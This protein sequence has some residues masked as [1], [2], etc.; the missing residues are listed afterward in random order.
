MIVV[1]GGTGVLGSAIVRRLL[2]AGHTARVLTR[3]PA[4]ASALAARG[5]GIAIADL[6]DPDALRVA[7]RDA[8]HVITTANAFTGGGTEAVSAVDLQGT[9]NLVA[10]AH[11]AGVR[12]FVFTSAR[13]PREFGAVD[14]FAAKFANE[15]YVRGSGIPYTILQ[16]TAFMETWARMILD[17][18]VGKGVARVFGPGDLPVNYVAVADVAAVAV[19]AL[20]RADTVN[21]A[22]EIGGPENL[23]TL[24]VVEIVERVTGRRAK[25]RHLPV[26][27]MKVLPALVRPF[28]PVFARAVQAGAL[29]AT[30]PQPFDPAPMLARFPFTPTRLEDWVR[31]AVAV[32]AV[33]TRGGAP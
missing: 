17:D 28:N 5:A 19:M 32:A 18:V 11:D 14:Y 30:I 26:A 16:P 4:R 20:D 2:E 10:A 29:T 8:T 33:R 13:L 9:R 1:A 6:R 24:Q 25:R 12:R 27:V 21:A 15:D 31:A 22:V 23:T 3:D 7:C